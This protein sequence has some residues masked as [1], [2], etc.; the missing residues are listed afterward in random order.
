MI[1]M[2]GVP[3]AGALLQRQCYIFYALLPNAYLFLS[4][5]LIG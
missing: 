5:F 4:L 2:A 3:Q 1:A